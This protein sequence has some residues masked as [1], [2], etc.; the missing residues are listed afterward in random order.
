MWRHS[1]K[2]QSERESVT[3]SER[4]IRKSVSESRWRVCPDNS[5]N[6]Q[7]R[8]GGGSEGD[9]VVEQEDEQ[10]GLA[11][12]HEDLHQAA[13]PAEEEDEGEGGLPQLGL[14]VVQRGSHPQPKRGAGGARHSG[15]LQEDLLARLGGSW[16]VRGELEGG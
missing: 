9:G 7:V 13:L 8:G 2:S 4:Q 14:R 3:Q 5:S 10:G 12:R 16:V 1:W 15:Q 6:G 11:G